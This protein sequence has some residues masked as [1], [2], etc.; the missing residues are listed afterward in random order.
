MRITTQM[1]MSRYKRDVSDAFASM[2]T[3]MQHAYDYRAFDKPSDDPLAA[4]QTFEVHW[5]MSENADYTNNIQNM[6]GFTKTADTLL[7][8][9]NSI[10][11]DTGNNNA[12]KTILQN[13]NGGMN[14][15]NRADAA[16][17]LITI[18]DSIIS[19]MN[20]KYG[21]SYI[22]GGSNSGSAPFQMINNELYYRG[23]NVDTGVNINGAS[24]TVGYTDVNNKANS[25]QI[26]FGKDIGGK[27]N[28]YKIEIASP[29]GA[30]GA[31][32]S[33]G[34]IKIS[35]PSSTTKDDLQ[36]FLNGTTNGANG[37]TFL[38]DLQDGGVTGL[39][40]TSGITI[41][42]LPDNGTDPVAPQGTP[43][44]SSITDVVDLASLANENVYVDIGLGITSTNG[45]IDDQSAFDSA[46]PGIKYLGYGTKTITNDDGTKTVPC[47]IC[48]VLTKIADCLNNSKGES[49][50]DLIKDASQYIDSLN[51][52]Q[53]SLQSKQA[54]LGEKMSFLSDAASYASDMKI[55]L[56]DKDNN[57]EYIDYT[58]AVE[59]FYTQMYCYNASLKVGGQILQQSLMD[60]LK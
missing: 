54:E 11:S 40:S 24:A 10:L 20:A 45:K 4:A 55:S 3:A 25:L 21:D 15:G 58:D 19:K 6:D 27:L 41:S 7:Q 53:T 39:T 56:S 12:L 48:S 16:T 51:Q 57:V 22:F 60:Y 18:R 32:V 17:S 34:T 38:K 59:T 1:M 26:N 23:I 33:G 42:G 49:N 31:Q 8:N 5:Q 29:A 43:T 44:A 37:Q 50:S 13:I 47:N 28:N 46:M 30:L 2:N 36:K 14:E 52:S 35:I 9:V